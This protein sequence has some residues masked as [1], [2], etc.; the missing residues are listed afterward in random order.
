MKTEERKVRLGMV[1][2]GI[3]SIAYIIMGIAVVPTFA[4]QET[5]KWRM[6]S[7]DSAAA[8]STG[9][10]QEDFIDRIKKLSNGRIDITLYSGG[11]LVP[12]TELVN[13]MKTGMMDIAYTSGVYYSG[14]I[15]EANLEYAGLP[16][17]LLRNEDDI[18][19]V[20]WKRGIDQIIR[21][22]YAKKGVHY[23]NSIV[24]GDGN[25]HWSKKPIQNTSELKGHKIRA[26]GYVNKVFQKFGATPVTIPQEEAYSA[27]SQGVIDGYY[28][29]G[30]HYKMTKMYE[31]APYYYLPRLN[32]V[33]TMS[34]LISMDNW[35]K[36]PA[37]L[38]A[39]V[40]EEVRVYSGKLAQKRDAMHTQLVEEF[41]NTGVK[42]I[43]WPD[44]EIKKL[45][46]AGFSYLPE[47]AAKSPSC[48]KGI[49]ILTSYMKE[50]G[51]MK[52]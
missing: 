34:I 44:S 23:L 16:P 5:F 52:K 2:V 1:L 14:A 10:L 18:K 32:P 30:M 43:V 37:D 48:A 45:R 15:P 51:Y 19:E 21:E 6:Q 24:S 38:Q 27:L 20:Y 13:A 17:G 29:G 25:T 33:I 7:S 8:L 46:E 11:Q 41:K 47:I 26:F 49:D 31:V 40:A 36:L 22:G 50:K 35:K 4:A 9:Y 12:T 42:L 3:I 39:I 28:T